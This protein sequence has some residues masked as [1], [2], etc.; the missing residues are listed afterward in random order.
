SSIVPRKSKN[1]NIDALGYI[2]FS[3]INGKLV[4]KNAL[5]N[6]GG[7]FTFKYTQQGAIWVIPA[8][9]YAE[10]GAYIGGIMNRARIVTDKEIPFKFDFTLEIEPELTV[11]AGAGVKD[12]AS[13]G[14]YANAT[15]PLVISFTDDHL[16]WDLDGEIGIEAEF[17]VLKGTKTV[18]DGS[19]NLV[20]HYW[21]N[22][23]TAN[24]MYSA[25]DDLVYKSEV[26]LVDRDYLENTSGWLNNSGMLHFY[27]VMQD[28]LALTNLQTSVFN[29]AAPQ[30]VTFGDKMLMTWVEDDANRDTYNR[31]RLMY[32][33]YNNGIWSEPVPVCDDGKNDNNPVIVSDGKDVYFAWQKIDEIMTEENLTIEALVENAEIFTAKYD[34]NTN[35]IVDVNQVS[36]NDCYDYAHNIAIING[37]P[38]CYWAS[39]I[40][41]AMSTSNQ[42]IIYRYEFGGESNAIANDKNYILSI[43][44]ASVNGKENVAFSMDA[45]GNTSSTN[46]ITVYTLVDGVEISF[47]KGENNVAY[48]N[49]FYGDFNGEETLF[50]SDMTNIYYVENGETKTVFDSNSSI[51][52]NFNY[53]VKD[54]IPYL[55]WT[56]KEEVGNAVYTSSYENGK[57]SSPVRVS[58]TGTQL[59]SVDI[60]V[61]NNAFKGVCTSSELVYNESKQLYEIV[62][63]NLC[64]F[65]IN[66]VQDISLDDIYIEEENIV[67][68]EETEFEV[69]VTNNGTEQ[70]NEVVFC[71]YDSKGYSETIT[72]NVNLQPGEGKFVSLVYKAPEDYSYRTLSVSA[73]SENIIDSNSENDIV[74]KEIGK[75]NI[76]LTESEILNVDGQHIITAIVTNESDVVAENI[77]LNILFNDN[78]NIIDKVTIDSIAPRENQIF[79][80]VISEDNLIFENEND[81]CKFNI[82]VDKENSTISGNKICYIIEKYTELECG[83]VLTEVV[84][85]IQPTCIEDGQRNT[86]CEICDAVITSESIPA[87][88]HDYATEYT[89]DIEPTL[90]SAGSKS[91]HCTRCDAKTDIIEIEKLYINSKDF[92]GLYEILGMLFYVENGEF[93]TTYTGLCKH[94]EKWYY[95]ENGKVNKSFA[96]L[97]KYSGK[98]YYI[99]EGVVNT[100]YT[101][102]VK[103]SGKWYHVKDGVKT[104]YTGLVKHTDGKY[105]YVKSGVKATFNGLVKYNSKW[106]YVKDGV[107]NTSYTGLLKHTDVKYYYFKSGVKTSFNGLVKYNSKWY[108]V[109]D[110]VKTT[111]TGLV[112][113]TDGKYYYVKSGVKTSFNGLVKYNSKWYYVKSGVVNTSYTGLVKHTDGKYY[114]VKKGVKTSYTGTVTYN[115]KKYKVKNGV[116]V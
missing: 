97:F 52:G 4:M 38:V 32:S 108:Y 13:A 88:G 36:E 116:K 61:H 70:V 65:Q 29:Q 25:G 98:W 16:K 99:S 87:L 77:D 50:V 35:S 2:E 111:Y 23:A 68:G 72:K 110:G 93:N 21:G 95:V 45:D 27:S 40:D 15:A 82:V 1:F 102:L 81:Y 26:E 100:D 37:S 89:V 14:I 109:K 83:H 86:V 22:S 69:Y 94:Y 107:V 57:W 106:Y 60:I 9:V 18:F 63:T 8:Y 41:N 62:Q 101:G 71:V 58:D 20:D 51:S 114:Y 46:D 47:D 113:H 3:F 24:S 66:E 112:K 39:C 96:G 79:S 104:T 48:T 28:G 53:I 76:V 59:S 91:R 34:S 90:S 42:N 103:Y 73:S 49:A 64:S 80:Y 10:M 30:I 19:V 84:D 44:A 67:I 115:G 92:T 54:D 7:E 6:I 43:D 85:T 78:T 56:E 11:G 55:F 5:V 105:Y 33:V 17:I 74:T 75:S 12:I 31:M